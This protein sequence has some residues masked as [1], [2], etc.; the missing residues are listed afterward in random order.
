MQA[1]AAV[2]LGRAAELEHPGPQASYGAQLGDRHELLVAGRQPELDQPGGIV[3]RDAG[4][5]EGAQVVRP[6]A[7]T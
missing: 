3:D 7:S 2:V 4:G 1:H 5:V 6:S